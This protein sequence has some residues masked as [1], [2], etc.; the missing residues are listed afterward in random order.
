MGLLILD[1]D[2]YWSEPNILE[3]DTFFIPRNGDN[4]TVEDVVYTVVGVD[5]DYD[6]EHITITVQNNK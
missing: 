6:K 5:I 1:R 4:I 2:S 3:I